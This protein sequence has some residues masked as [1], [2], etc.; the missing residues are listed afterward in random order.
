MIRRKIR[1]TFRTVDDQRI[2][3]FP[4]GDGKFYRSREGSA[5]HTDDTHFTAQI[6]QF[7]GIQLFRVHRMKLHPCILKIIVNH[8][9]ID[10]GSVCYDA[11]KHVHHLAGNRSVNRRTD[12]ADRLPYFLAR[13]DRIALLNQRLAG[14]ADML[15]KRDGHARR[16]R[17]FNNRKTSRRRLA[18]NAFLRMD[19]PREAINGTH[20][21]SSFLYKYQ[22]N[23]YNKHYSTIHSYRKDEFPNLSKLMPDVP[24]SIWRRR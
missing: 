21:N 2:Y 18:A 12:K 13:F 4:F 7:F 3:F 11:G 23:A 19:P 24:F 17:H 9:G 6:G 14:R 5:A 15:L 16:L 1:L 8:N 22:F 20:E 10:L